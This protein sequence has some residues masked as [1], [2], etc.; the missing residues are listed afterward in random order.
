MK[1]I[2]RSVYI[3][4]LSMI[5]TAAS[6]DAVELKS[7]PVQSQ[8]VS[9]LN[10]RT[11]AG[12]GAFNQAA[13]ISNDEAAFSDQ[14]PRPRSVVRAALLSVLLP[15][16][17]EY[18]VGHRNKAK[19]FFGAEALT[20]VSFFAFRTYGGWRKDDYIRLAG[21]RA[22]ASL[23]GKDD[24]F[25]DWVGFYRDIDEFNT[26][27]RVFDI[28]RPYLEDTPENH[29]RWLT[30]SDQEAYREIKNSSREAYR[31][32]EFMIGVAIINRVISVIDAVRDAKRSNSR[33]DRSFGHTA[34]LNYRLTIDPFSGRQQV[35]LTVFTSL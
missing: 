2:M 9:D 3:L 34:G 17:G 26:L 20:W 22:G 23:E 7:T 27:G 33:L 35:K 18:Y 14:E 28:D 12:M 5:L 10:Q 31:R 13:M 19:Y 32:S 4:V 16:L 11:F 6:G 1:A 15:G 8:L 24:D 29:W 30:E 21:E 25:L